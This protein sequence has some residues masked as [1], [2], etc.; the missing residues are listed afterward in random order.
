MPRWTEESRDKQRQLCL[1]NKPWVHSTGAKTLEGKK[2]SSRNSLKH[3]MYTK[4]EKEFSQLY[5]S[6]TK[7]NQVIFTHLDL[8]YGI[9][10]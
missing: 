6:H 2:A 4:K 9:K 8:Y 1:K 3:G 7:Q 10:M 5:K